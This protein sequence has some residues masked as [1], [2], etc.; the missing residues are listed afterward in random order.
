MLGLLELQLPETL[1]LAVMGAAAQAVWHAKGHIKLIR[2]FFNTNC[3]ALSTLAAAWGYRQTWFS[4]TAEAELLR[5]TVAG[6]LYFIVSTVPLSIIISL[7]EHQ[8]IANVW[9]N[10][11]NWLLFYYLIGV[12]LAE[13][14]HTANQRLGFAFTLALLPVAYAIYHS[15]RLYL[16][17]LEQEKAHAQSM[18]SLHLRTIEALAMAIEAKDECTHEHL[19]RVQV[20]SIELAKHLGLP[21]E[22]VNAL[23]AASILHDIGKLAVPDY[24]IS[25]PGKLTP[26]EFDKMKV[27][28]IVGAEILEQVAFPYPVS[29]IVRAHHEKWDGSGYPD[30]LREEQIPIGARILSAV[31]CLDALASDRQYRRALPLDD[32]MNYVASLSG[33]SFDPKVVDVLKRHYVEF[34]RLA[35]STPLNATRLRKDI[36]VSRGGAPD[37]GFEKTPGGVADATEELVKA[38]AA[39]V[40]SARRE[41]QGVLELAQDVAGSL[42]GEELLSVVAGRLK[43]IVPYDCIAVYVRQGDVL[44]TKYVSGENSRTFAG[45]EIPVGQGLSG[46]VVE[47]GKPIINGNPSVEPGYLKDPSRFSVLNS[48]LSIPLR[49]SVE[50]VTGALTLY[51]AEKDAYSRDHLRIL[52]SISDKVARAVEIACLAG[53]QQQ[54][55][56]DE[57]T[58]LP[59]ASSLYTYLQQELGRCELQG[60]TL[61]VL[62]CDLDGFKQVNDRYGHLSGDALL[63]SV[64]AILQSNCRSSDYVA[65]M[66]GDEFVVVLSGSDVAELNGRIEA[67]DSRIRAAGQ[68]MFSDNSVGISVGAACFPENG[69]DVDSLLSYADRDLERAKRARKTTDG[70]V[71]QLARSLK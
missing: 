51:A 38:H 34:E 47:N 36:I 56:R 65:R 37:A 39:S 55:N 9:K 62:S 14:V 22:Q 23:Q 41:M 28:T 21:E 68:E 33:R 54:A 43:Q 16:G 13:I 26:E 32:A 29:P 40:A 44:K 64:G 27:H 53:A 49:D 8:P 3:I 67:L 30:G 58:G 66:G 24:I 18:A 1:A 45:L 4:G 6:V 31:D 46:W 11:Y 57:L 35:Q 52:L 12:S 5:L 61:T 60:K 7:T 63:R 70:E 42:R 2:V 25:K 50:Q 59:N 69:E 48:A 10:S 19:R 20:Y 17:R 15:Y 71:L